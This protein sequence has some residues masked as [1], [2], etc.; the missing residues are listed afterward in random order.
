MHTVFNQG[1]W[2]A[3]A[4]L[5]FVVAL[6]RFS[7]PPTNR[8]GTTFILF[9]TGVLFYYALLIGLWLLVIVLLSAGSYGVDG[10]GPAVSVSLK[11][12]EWLNPSLP[13]VGLLVI[14]VASR[15]KR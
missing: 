15:F 2:V 10:I 5:L 1:L 12:N 13:V 7:R 3:S 9:Y 6:V 14:A 11:A 8:T 4:L